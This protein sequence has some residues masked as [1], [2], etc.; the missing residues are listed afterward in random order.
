[1]SVQTACD[2]CTQGVMDSTNPHLYG[3]CGCACH[4]SEPTTPTGRRLFTDNEPMDMMESDG[5]LWEDIVAIEAE[6]RADALRE[7]AERVLA[8]DALDGPRSMDDYHDAVLAILAE[9]AGH[10]HNMQIVRDGE[11]PYCVECGH[12]DVAVANSAAR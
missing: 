8:L 1:M 7:A 5:V 2:R 12:E 11:A 9:R 4:E 3:T 10:E 6:A